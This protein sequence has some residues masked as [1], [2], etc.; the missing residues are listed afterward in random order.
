MSGEEL[1]RA[2][3]R[4]VV[5][6]LSILSRGFLQLELFPVVLADVKEIVEP[7]QRESR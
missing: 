5:C 2:L 4:K 6:R 1:Y 3:R 7:R